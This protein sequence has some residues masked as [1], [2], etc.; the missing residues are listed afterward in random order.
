MPI[1]VEIT[2]SGWLLSAVA[3]DTSIILYTDSVSQTCDSHHK[4][5]YVGIVN[6]RNTVD[7]LPRLIRTGSRLLAIHTR[8]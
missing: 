3:K 7:K 4:W 5:W 2:S 8:T 6:G 1:N